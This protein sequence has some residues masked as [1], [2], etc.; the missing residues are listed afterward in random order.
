M[1]G[2]RF[3]STSDARHECAPRSWGVC[4]SPPPALCPF[5]SPSPFLFPCVL[6]FAAFLQPTPQQT[7]QEPADKHK[8]RR[9]TAKSATTAQDQKAGKGARPCTRTEG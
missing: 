7:E 1:N 4:S 6:L 9:E 5:F 2:R 3:G 8:G